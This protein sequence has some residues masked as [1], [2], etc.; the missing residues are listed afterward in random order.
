MEPL[1]KCINQLH[2]CSEYCW[3]NRQC[4]CKATKNG[5]YASWC[6]ETDCHARCISTYSERWRHFIWYPTT[7]YGN[8]HWDEFL[9]YGNQRA[10]RILIFGTGRSLNFLQNS[11]SWFMDGTFLTVPPQFSQFYTIHRLSHGR[12]IVGAYGQLP[13][14][15][16]ETYNGFLTQIRNLTNHVN[17]QSIMIDF[18]QSVM[19]ALDQV[20]SIGKRGFWAKTSKWKNQNFLIY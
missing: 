11:D 7:F 5:N 6:K 18:E 15:R 13:N 1:K 19:C 9:K 8:K 12:H 2:H 16:L 10:D 20:S 17:P 4:S 14:K 3:C